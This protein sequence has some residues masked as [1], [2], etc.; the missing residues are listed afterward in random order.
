MASDQAFRSALDAFLA[1]TPS[2]FFRNHLFQYLSEPVPTTN[3]DA[4]IPSVYEVD[5]RLELARMLRNNIRLHQSDNDFNF[6]SIQLSL[7]LM[8]PID[9]LRRLEMD[10]RSHE[11]SEE[12]VHQASSISAVLLEPLHD[13]LRYC[14]FRFFILFIIFSLTL[15]VLECKYSSIKDKK[16]KVPGGNSIYIE[17]GP[18]K[19]KTKGRDEKEKQKVYILAQKISKLR[20]LRI[21]TGRFNIADGSIHPIPLTFAAIRLLN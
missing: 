9:R 14:K 10:T 11:E 8:I 2:E 4:W 21:Q 13:C 17:Q 7:L 6:T 15:V 5:I 12:L 18:P 16:R 19:G 20:D 1:S 3:S